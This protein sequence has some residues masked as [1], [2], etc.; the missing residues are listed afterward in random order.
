MFGSVGCDRG[1]GSKES[2]PTAGI[3]KLLRG[4]GGCLRGRR[5]MTGQTGSQTNAVPEA[6]VPRTGR[7]EFWN[8]AV[9]EAGAPNA[10]QSAPICAHPWFPDRFSM[11]S[12]KAQRS[13][14][15]RRAGGRRSWD[16]SAA[17]EPSQAGRPDDAQCRAGFPNW[18]T[19]GQRSINRVC[20]LRRR[21]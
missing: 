16:R 17:Q 7:N 6:D 15:R 10:P 12:M 19:A 11:R 9:P 1:T 20:E 21:G 3:R 8:D 4:L 14:Q 2:L 13:I 5:A 18:H